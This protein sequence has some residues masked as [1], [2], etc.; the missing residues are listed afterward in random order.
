MVRLQPEPI[1]AED[2]VASVAADEVGAVAI[3]LGTV[4]SHSGGRRVLYLDYEAYKG[5]AETEMA[6]IE[7]E[8]LERFGVSR[9]AVVH[10]SG[11]LAIGQVSVGVAVASAHRAH[12]LDAC[13]FVIDELKRT[14][15]IWKK[16]HF[17]GGAV[18]VEGGGGTPAR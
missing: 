7:R 10:R 17:E 16:E 5:M 15:P 18:W 6:R 8:A 1:R 4:R 3:F 14:V 12:A 2:L 9:I 11:R 13:R